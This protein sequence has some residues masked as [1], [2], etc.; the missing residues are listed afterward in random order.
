MNLVK[1]DKLEVWEFPGA[2]VLIYFPHI[3]EYAV[4]KI[5]MD[6]FE[7]YVDI[8]ATWIKSGDPSELNEKGEIYLIKG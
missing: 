2:K 7:A 6:D 3:D 8:R 4:G 1:I 5:E